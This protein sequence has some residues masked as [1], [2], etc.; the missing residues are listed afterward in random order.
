MENGQT[1]ENGKGNCC[2]NL[3]KNKFLVAFIGFA[4]ILA[5]FLV[6][7]CAGSRTGFRH[8]RG[9]YYGG[10]GMMQYGGFGGREG[11]GYRGQPVPMMGGYG[12]G[13][14]QDQTAPVAPAVTTT[15]NPQ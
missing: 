13:V 1:Q 6:G 14:A 8:S 7:F 3:F 5:V 15:V 4:I 11:R 12:Q 10:N 9:G 2:Q